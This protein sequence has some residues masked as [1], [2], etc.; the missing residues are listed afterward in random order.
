MPKTLLV[1]VLVSHT[2]D[3][4][5]FGIKISSEEIHFYFL[6]KIQNKNGRTKVRGHQRPTKEPQQDRIHSHGHMLSSARVSLLPPPKR[7]FTSS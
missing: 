4:F 3:Q 5:S 6:R 7:P 2:Q 1:K